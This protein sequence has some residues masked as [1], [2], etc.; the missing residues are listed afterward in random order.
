MPYVTTSCPVLPVHAKHENGLAGLEGPEDGLQAP[1]HGRQIRAPQHGVHGHEHAANALGQR[2]R[3]LFNAAMAHGG[4][5]GHTRSAAV[6][7]QGHEG[8]VLPPLDVVQGFE[9]T[10]VQPPTGGKLLDYAYCIYLFH[11]KLYPGF[12]IDPVPQQFIFSFCV[13]I[14]IIPIPEDNNQ[15]HK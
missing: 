7:D 11:L 12:L 2:A 6:H 14:T 15:E 9:A 10:D 13:S 4:Q 1:A 8:A 5:A 3:S